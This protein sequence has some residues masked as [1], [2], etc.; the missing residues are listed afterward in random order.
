MKH[1]LLA[2]VAMV[3]PLVAHAQTS[4]NDSDWQYHPKIVAIRGIV[5]EIDSQLRKGAFTLRVRP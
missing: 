2:A 3:A 1:L 5:S 4:V